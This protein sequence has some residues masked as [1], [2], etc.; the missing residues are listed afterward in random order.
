MR[1]RASR[2][3][4][5]I[6]Y[7]GR[8]RQSLHR[9]GP[10]AWRWRSGALWHGRGGRAFRPFG[11]A[12]IF[13][14]RRD[15]ELFDPKYYGVV[16]DYRAL[17]DATMRATTLISELFPGCVPSWDN[18]A[19]GR[20]EAFAFPVRPQTEY[21]RWLRAA[22]AAS[23]RKFEGDER[24]VFIN[25]WNEW[26]EGTYLEPDRHFGFAYLA[27]TCRA[28]NSLSLEMANQ[29]V[30]ESGAEWAPTRLNFKKRARRMARLTL[31]HLA[32]VAEE[33]AWQLRRRR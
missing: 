25:A 15:L 8:A 2:V 6:S 14:L 27:E 9:N 12:P 23:I 16:R 19:R 11:Q 5:N 13:R 22:C 10:N 24:L 21:G 29:P 28:L 4:A 18:E 20:G 3:G 33:I 30:P 32:N 17:A 26:A 31:N 1:D 7:F